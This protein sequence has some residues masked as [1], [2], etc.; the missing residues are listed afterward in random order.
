M[1]ILY[2]QMAESI[3]NG[4][5]SKVKE[6]TQKALDE[7]CEPK[8]IISNGLLPGMNEVGILFKE[9]E[10][11]VPE[12]LV[13]AKAMSAG[14]ELIKPL[15][16]DGEVQ[17]AGKCLFATV[18]GDLHDIGKKLVSMLMEGAGYEII[19]LGVDIDPESI[20]EE[21]K[22]HKPDLVGMSAMLTTT[23][24]AMKDT[25]EALKE[26]GLYEKVKVMIGGAPVTG[27]YA[28]EIGAY[29]SEDASA[30][31]DLANQLIRAS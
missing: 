6:L 14:M 1:S 21:V 27:K 5:V 19:D 17:S 30:A 16:K 7:G 15:L 26:N 10:L 20:V 28:D 2:E 8:E 3:E 18:K 31:V 12:V 22:K 25:V 29:Y 13:A 9:G 24:V 11:F 4:M 23:M